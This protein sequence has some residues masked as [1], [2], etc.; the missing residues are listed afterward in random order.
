MNSINRYLGLVKS[1][2]EFHE[3]TAKLHSKNETKQQFHQGIANGFSGL[4]E[5]LLEV[6]EKLMLQTDSEKSNMTISS[7]EYKE[8][9]QEVIN[10]LSITDS[11]R[12]DFLLVDII[13]Q[14]NDAASLDRI[15]VDL[16]QQTKEVHTRSSVNARLY[17]M[18]QKGKIDRD[19]KTKG[20]Y[21]SAG[22]KAASG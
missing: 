12:L 22:K 18:M 4:E 9:P 2:A 21:V 8:L 11:D 17:R 14:N 5:F 10:E 7:A 16:Y 13:K 20:V 19:K 1:Q 6:K 3:K 15:I